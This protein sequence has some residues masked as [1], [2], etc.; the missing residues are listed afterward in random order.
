M[1]PLGGLGEIGKNMTVIEYDGRIVVV[2]TGL[3][4]PTAEMHGIDLVLPDFSYLRDRADSIEAIVLTHGHEDH[5]GA[6]PYVLREIGP[7]PVIYGG[8]LTIGMVRS[9]LDEHK[10]ADTAN[11]QELPAGEKVQCGPFQIELVH[12]AH[13]IPDMRGVLLTTELGSMLMTGDYKFDQTP[14]DGRPADVSRLAELGKEGLLLLCGDSTNADRPGIAPSESS[15][16]PALLQEFSRCEGRII[17]TSF[18]S[19]IHRVQQVIDAAVALDRKVALVGRSMRKNFNIA[20]NLG[21]ANAPDGL[22]IQPREIENFPDSKV[23]VIST[24][25]QGEPL[26]ALRRMANNDHRDVQLH[27]GDTVV[28]SATPV[29]G[30]ER[31]VNET[32]DR[33]YEIGA[34]VITAKDAPIHASGHGWQEELKLMLNL[35]KPR[36]VLPVHGDFKRLRLHSELAEAVGVDPKNIFQG[37]NGLPL[38]IDESG[39]RFGEDIHAGVIY[40]DGVNIGEPDDAALRDR[41]AISADGIF[42]VVATISSD[43]GSVVADPEVI[44]RG[45]AFLEEADALVEEI[46]DLVEDLLEDLAEA[47]TREVDLIQEDLHDAIGK[48]VFQRLH[49]RPMILPVVVEV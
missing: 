22:F 35:T 20:S 45:V 15:V 40:V 36:Y 32:I 9:K 8:L 2:D 31:A 25:S 46:S 1:L 47:G 4:F 41:R 11:L 42:I 38:E 24:G 37:R 18:A 16:G 39:A 33:I 43:D 19:N 27:S 7:P 21:M 6:L 30:N 23:V 49:R 10:L 29:P 17:V 44:F 48:F 28:F 26:S 3:M 12:L 14:V 34:T 5:V 13:S